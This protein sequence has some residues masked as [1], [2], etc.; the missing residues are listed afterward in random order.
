MLFLVI[1]YDLDPIPPL[2]TLLSLPEEDSLAALPAWKTLLDRLPADPMGLLF[3]NVVEQARQN[4]PPPNETSLGAILNQELDAIALAAVPEENGMRVEIA[5]MFREGA[6]ARPELRALFDLPALDPM[7]WT[8]LP[9]NSA[10]A[11]FAHD[12][13]I[14]WP[15]LQEIFGLG[16]MEQVRD[17]TYLD[18][19][20]DLFG[21]DGP[22][23]G[24]FALAITPPLPNQPISKDLAAA[25]LLLLAQDATKTQVAHVRTDMIDRGAIFGPDEVEGVNLQTQVGTEPSG[26]AISFG[27]DG[28]AMLFGSSPD[29]IGQALVAEHEGSGLVTTDFFEAVLRTLPDESQFVFFWDSESLLDLARANMTEQELNNTAFLMT[30]AFDAFGLGVQLE[31]DRLDGIIYF[32]FHE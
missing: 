12:A 8:A 23:T 19:E 21:A 29:I 26:Y 32:L 24:D 14:V 2:Q 20:A 25:Q 22:L 16:A 11:L 18:L 15:L 1:G 10:I 28:D 17:T 30:E 13:S 7:A 3:F 31:P 6:S 9:N 5:G 27:F 4:P